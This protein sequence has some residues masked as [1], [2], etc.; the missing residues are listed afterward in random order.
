MPRSLK[1][2]TF[3]AS[4]TFVLGSVGYLVLH[5]VMPHGRVFGALYRMFLYHDE[6]PF[7]YIMVVALTYAVIATAC[8]LRW[9]HLLGWR[10]FATIVGVIVA[11]ILIASVP[12]GVLWKLHDMQA[13]YF[14][15]GARFWGDLFWGASMGLQVG[16]L[17][18]ALSPPFNIIGLVVGYAVTIY[19]FKIGLVTSKSLPL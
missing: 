16:W 10:R 15:T 7:Q 4:S 3:F 8:A 1:L 2:F 17:V 19:G 18:I 5:A 12:G 9:S 14:P 6:Y 13:G 11:T